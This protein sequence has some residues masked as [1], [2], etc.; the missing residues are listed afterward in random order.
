[1]AIE[2]TDLEVRNHQ[3]CKHHQLRYKG[4]SWEFQGDT[5]E[6]QPLTQG[7][8]GCDTIRG[9]PRVESCGSTDSV[10]FFSIGM[11]RDRDAISENVTRNIFGGFVVMDMRPMR[12]T[13]GNTNGSN[14]VTPMRTKRMET[15]ALLVNDTKHQHRCWHGCRTSDQRMRSRTTMLPTDMAFGLMSALMTT[16]SELVVSR[17]ASACRGQ[18]P[19]CMTKHIFRR[20]ST[21]PS[22]IPMVFDYDTPIRCHIY[23]FLA[24]HDNQVTI[25]RLKDKTTD[26]A[27][28]GGR[29]ART[30]KG[31]DYMA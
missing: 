10:P 1:M 13:S 16:A 22:M 27:A 3:T 5:H 24:I 20:D 19:R 18:D 7:L 15:R 9:E 29:V 17:M 11:D 31:R 8:D 26:S 4:V 21:I 14:L 25:E 23:R 12:L 28:R 6:F 2:Y 30:A